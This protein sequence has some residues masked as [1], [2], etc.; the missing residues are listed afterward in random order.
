MRGNIGPLV[1]AVIAATTTF[2]M[3][4]D[5]LPINI[6]RNEFFVAT[7]Y[8]QDG[9]FVYKYVDPNSGNLTDIVDVGD[10]YVNAKSFSDVVQG[11]FTVMY[12]QFIRVA[13]VEVT[14]GSGVGTSAKFAVLALA[15]SVSSD[16]VLSLNDAPI[17]DETSATTEQVAME[18]ALTS[19][20]GVS[21]AEAKHAISVTQ[22]IES[23]HGATTFA[24]TLYAIR[25]LVT[26]FENY[27]AEE[28]VKVRIKS[29]LADKY[30]RQHLDY[31]N[32]FKGLA[33][34]MA[35]LTPSTSTLNLFAEETF[36]Y[37][38]TAAKGIDEAV[39]AIATVTSQ[40]TVTT[41]SNA[42]FIVT[43]VASMGV[44]SFISKLTSF[45]RGKSALQ[46][47][48]RNLMRAITLGNGLKMDPD[49]L[50]IYNAIDDRGFGSAG[51]TNHVRSNLK[52]TAAR[53]AS[54]TKFINNKIRTI[55][56]KVLF[57]WN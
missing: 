40:D 4:T 28:I 33:K 11:I 9:N 10:L 27:T 42:D 8:T 57:L 18:N 12:N 6:P 56:K 13:F 22:A 16:L 3:A 55:A 39:T 35:D 50:R 44:D 21:T 31:T 26:D 49:A 1:L 29:I 54:T 45:P 34:F 52:S 30:P 38:I 5:T 43:K 47:L 17:I 19:F 23:L 48:A 36:G 20:F 51:V 53:G 25:Y 24:K 2:V 46:K 41:G 7:V 15:S 32:G 37:Y 14:K